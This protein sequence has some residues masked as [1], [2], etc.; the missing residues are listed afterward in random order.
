MRRV[1]A[2]PDAECGTRK[3]AGK[4]IRGSGGVRRPRWR[5]RGTGK[6]F[7]FS[8]TCGLCEPDLNPASPRRSSPSCWV[9]RNA[10]WNRGSRVA[11]KRVRLPRH[12]SGWQ[13]CIPKYCVTSRHE[14]VCDPAAT[15]AC[16]W[17]LKKPVGSIIQTDQ[18]AWSGARR[19]Q[20]WKK[21]LQSKRLP[22]RLRW[23][24]LCHNAP[25]DS[26]SRSG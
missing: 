16:I 3:E 1:A 21:P 2:V 25:R 10:H 19:C 15:R 26:L 24:R 22:P 12:S 9:S 17:A 6:R 5:R 11:A 8:R 13:N 7:T 14:P 20:K 18:P 23:Q 4:I